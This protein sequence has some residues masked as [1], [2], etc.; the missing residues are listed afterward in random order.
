ML[1]FEDIPDDLVPLTAHMKEL[2][3]Q[4]TREQPLLICLD[5]VDQLVGSQDGNKM[6]WLPTKLPPH[7]K[8]I[9][10]CTKEENNPRL[11][12]GPVSIEN[13]LA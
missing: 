5:S 12:Q 13:I 1:P 8:I 7:C 2:L 11:C 6:A 10:S 9:V 3:N 4:A